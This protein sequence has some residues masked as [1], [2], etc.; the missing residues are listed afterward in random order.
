MLA[1]ARAKL[2]RAGL[3]HVQVRQADIYDLP[4]ADQSADAVVMHQV[5]HFLADP[6]RASARRRACWPLAAGC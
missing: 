4:L 6:Q 2:E 1:Y 5:L 3:Q